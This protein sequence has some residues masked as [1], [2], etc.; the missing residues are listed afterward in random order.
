MEKM[1]S[2]EERFKQMER[3]C[4]G[5]YVDEVRK[6]FKFRDTR[7]NVWSKKE[8]GYIDT[9]DMFT[10]GSDTITIRYGGY[11]SEEG[12]GREDL[13]EF[14][15][16]CMIYSIEQVGEGLFVDADG[17]VYCM[18]HD[19]DYALRN[20][21]EVTIEKCGV[22]DDFLD[23]DNETHRHVREWFNTMED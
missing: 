10:Y 6:D 22:L 1:N 20:H 12:R 7:K 9:T 4:G 3:M 19:D 11:M 8:K 2:F 15:E 14:L 18:A 21:G 17:N 23:E 13:L 16:S 5:G